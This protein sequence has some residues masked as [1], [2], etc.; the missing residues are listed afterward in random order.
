[1]SRIDVRMPSGEGIAVGQTATFKLPI[2]RR[3]HELRLFGA[4]TTFAVTD[5][6]EIRVFING[7]VAQRFSGAQR[8]AMNRFDGRHPA[9]I[10]ATSFEL[11]IP[12]NRYKLNT[13]AGEEE[14]ALNTG[15][16][17]PKTAQQITSLYLEVD[18]ANPGGITGTP[19]F[20]LTATQSE[21]LPGGPGTIMFVQRFNRNIAGSGDFDIA[22]LPRGDAT[23]VALNRIFF[24]PDANNISRIVVERNQ[25]IIFD[26][27]AQSNARVQS[28]AYRVPQVGWYVIDKTEAALGGD[29]I[30]L[31]GAAD[32]RFKLTTDGAMNPAILAEYLGTLAN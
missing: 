7:Q 2:G 28:D 17:D 15:S 8:D 10:D 11:V 3:F 12:F 16:A 14:T 26:R 13:L 19:T 24:N 21:S 20:L 18:L 31:L 32:F 27:T 1:M 30:D 6:T 29:P 25:Y 23:R 4:A 9:T 22:D 5:I